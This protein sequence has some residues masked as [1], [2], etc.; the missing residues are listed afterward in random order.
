MMMYAE[1]AIKTSCPCVI[2]YKVKCTKS[3]TSTHLWKEPGL[4]LQYCEYFLKRAQESLVYSICS[5]YSKS[6][7]TLWFSYDFSSVNTSEGFGMSLGVLDATLSGF[8][9]YLDN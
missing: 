9:V 8:H 5:F 7:V 6:S 3:Y 4:C 1:F 2:Y